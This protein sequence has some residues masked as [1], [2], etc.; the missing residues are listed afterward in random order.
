MYMLEVNVW[1]NKSLKSNLLREL[2][3]HLGWKN[4]RESFSLQKYQTEY[5][6][7]YVW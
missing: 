6:K 7:Q 5:V 1:E 4:Q 3:L 2:Y